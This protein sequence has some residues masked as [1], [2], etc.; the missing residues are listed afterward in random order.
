MLEEAAHTGKTPLTIDNQFLVL[1]IKVRPWHVERNLNL[2]RET[3]QFG[4]QRTV[5]WFRPWLNRAFRKG[6]RFVWNH[7]IKIEVD[8]VT[9][10]LATRTRAIGI[11]EGEESRLRLFIPCSVALAFKTLT[12]A[13]TFHG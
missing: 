9:E 13:Q 12:E 5:F 4:K 8:C 6:F 3:L 10:S 2:L 1:W 11:V 7:K